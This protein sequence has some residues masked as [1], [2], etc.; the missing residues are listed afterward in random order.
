MAN[1][2]IARVGSN[3]DRCLN[4][5]VEGESRVRTNHCDRRVS[6]ADFFPRL[7]VLHLLCGEGDAPHRS[8]PP[9]LLASLNSGVSCRGGMILFILR[10]VKGL[11]PK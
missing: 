1:P 9:Y 5:T 10:S 3:Q 6:H 8:P 2:C 7:M 4:A 11:T